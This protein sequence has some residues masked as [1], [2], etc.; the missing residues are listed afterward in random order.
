MIRVFLRHIV[1]DFAQWREAFDGME[2]LRQAGG[3]QANG[4]FHALDDPNDVTVWH[5]FETREK[6]EAFITSD[7]FGAA[8]AD[9]GVTGEPIAWLTRE[10]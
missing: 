4:I 3:V 8:L 7:V 5:D 2:P 1:E 10:A 9:A 6:A